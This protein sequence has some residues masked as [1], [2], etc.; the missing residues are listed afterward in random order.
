MQ[1]QK[2][3]ILLLQHLIPTESELDSRIKSTLFKAAKP[4]CSKWRVLEALD[5][6]DSAV[7]RE[8]YKRWERTVESLP[9]RVCCCLWCVHRCW[10][11]STPEDKKTGAGLTLSHILGATCRLFRHPLCWRIT[12]FISNYSVKRG[13]IDEWWTSCSKHHT[14]LAVVSLLCGSNIRRSSYRIRK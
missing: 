5:K 8:N 4:T 12:A 14:S 3:Q 9:A 13:K 11:Q 7:L 6:V 2:Q 10:T 1:G